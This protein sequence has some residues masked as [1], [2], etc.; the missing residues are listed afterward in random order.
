M[1]DQHQSGHPAADDETYASERGE[2][3]ARPVDELI[4]LNPCLPL[5]TPNFYS[6][7]VDPKVLIHPVIKH[8][9]DDLFRMIFEVM[10]N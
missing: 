4:F 2:M 9:C 10:E 6:P 8:P 7:R 5:G 3:F 1:S